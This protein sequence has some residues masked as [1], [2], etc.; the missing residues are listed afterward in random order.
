LY[1]QQPQLATDL[2]AP[3]ARAARMKLDFISAEPF[4][5]AVRKERCRA[6]NGYRMI[7]VRQADGSFTLEFPIYAALCIICYAN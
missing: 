4:S 6:F 7:D 3:V 2:A 5:Q 1:V